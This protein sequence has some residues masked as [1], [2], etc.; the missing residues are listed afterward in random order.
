MDFEKIGGRQDLWKGV[1]VGVGYVNWL[2]ACLC[3][4]M[5]VFYAFYIWMI[6]CFTIFI[7]LIRWCFFVANLQP[8]LTIMNLGLLLYLTFI[9]FIKKYKVYCAIDINQ[10]GS[11]QLGIQKLQS[12]NCK[13]NNHVVFPNFVANVNH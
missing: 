11:S 13:E 6:V 3:S 10:W 12:W 1:Q 4:S 5:C 9:L 8:T 7:L 2:C